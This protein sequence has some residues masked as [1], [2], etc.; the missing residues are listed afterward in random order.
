MNG[1]AGPKQKKSTL[2]AR[3]PKKHPPPT[4]C[5]FCCRILFDVFEFFCCLCGMFWLRRRRRGGGLAVSAGGFLVAVGEE[6]CIAQKQ[7]PCTN[8]QKSHPFLHHQQPP[9]PPPQQQQKNTPPQTLTC[10]SRSKNASAA[11]Y[12]TRIYPLQT[13]GS[14]EMRATI[15]RPGPDE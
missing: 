4:A 8:S 3:T 11:N 9:P 10:S 13:S 12:N 5:C 14:G 15:F 1:P 7:R 6:G 2:P